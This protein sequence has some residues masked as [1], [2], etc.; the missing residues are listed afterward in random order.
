MNNGMSYEDKIINAIETIVD[1]KVENANYD[2]TIQAQIISCVDATIGKYKVQYQDSTFYAYSGSSDLVFSDGAEV[3]ILIPGNDMSR[4]KTILGTTKKL[5]VNYT[6][7]IDEEEAYEIIGNNCIDSSANFELCS[8]RPE[9][10]V[11]YDRNSEDNAIRLNLT[12]IE[13]YIRQSSSI[14]CA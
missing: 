8:Y 7:P 3:Y 12:S 14:I 10:R 13:T 6:N 11:I 5:G 2:K 1:N 9:T 4:D